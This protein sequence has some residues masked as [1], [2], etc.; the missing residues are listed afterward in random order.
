[1]STQ[2]GRTPW[3]RPNSSAPLAVAVFVVLVCA[4]IGG[5]GDSEATGPVPRSDLIVIDAMS[6][7]GSLD[8]PAVV[9]PH[10]AHTVTLQL[11]GDS[12]SRCHLTTEQGEMSLL[13]NRLADN[14]HDQVMEAYHAGCIDCHVSTVDEGR[15]AGPVTCG[16]CHTR[17]PKYVSSRVPMQMDKSL[18]YIHIA[19]TD[20]ECGRCHHQFDSTEQKLVYVKGQESSCRDCHRQVEQ[21]GVISFGVASHRQCLSCHAEMNQ[22]RLQCMGCHSAA[23]QLTMKTVDDPPR[24]QRGQPDFILLAANPK[25]R[26][27][28]KLRT[29]PFS[30]VGHEGFTDNCRVCHH[31]SL[32]ACSDC[33][34][35]EGNMYAGGVTLQQAMHDLVSEHSCVGCHNQQKEVGECLSCH[36]L[37]EQGR[38]VES[39]CV[40]CH[41]GPLPENLE[42]ARSRYRSLDQFRPTEAQRRLSFVGADIPDTVRIGSLQKE[43]QPAWM[44]HKEIVDTLLA[45][46]DNNRIATYFHGSRDVMCQGCHHHSPVGQRPPLCESCHGTP[47]DPHNLTRPGLYG[48]FHRQCIGCH[49]QMDIGTATDCVRCHAPIQGS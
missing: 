21:E 44:P 22:G 46:I 12:C 39:T 5:C 26:H 15:A 20:N 9:Y 16:E 30:H 23:Q 4:L 43:Y 11:V 47:F 34:L 49:E 24:L 31:E 27:Q 41:A 33:H 7:F 14:S 35:L 13:F 1:M 2:T 45:V 18:H 48:A 3:T 37:M 25:E 28:S 32:R 42:Q 17:S 19:A 10:D 29:V 8:R 36:G 38:L 6:Q 40:T